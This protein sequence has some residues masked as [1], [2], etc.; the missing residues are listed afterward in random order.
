MQAYKKVEIIIPRLESKHL[1]RL[2]DKHSING[3]SY[4]EGV[5]GRGDRGL[6]DGQGLSQAFSNAYFIIACS[7]AELE[8]ITESLRDLLED[9]GGICLVSDVHWLKH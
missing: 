1:I 2:L 9:V 8:K 5:K 4:L 3:Y 6:Q 7:E